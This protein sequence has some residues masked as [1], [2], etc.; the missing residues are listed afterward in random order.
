MSIFTKRGKSKIN[1]DFKPELNYLVGTPIKLQD[2][3][4]ENRLKYMNITTENLLALQE[5]KPH[6][7]EMKDQFLNEVLDHVYKFDEL[8]AIAEAHSSRER[9]ISVFSM[10]LD[11]LLEGT[12][13]EKYI[14]VRKRIGETHKRGELPVGW[15]IATYQTFNSLLI[16]Q[17]VKLYIDDPKKLSD[18]LV[19]MTDVM[20]FD[21]QLIVE[22]YLDSKVKETTLLYD[23]Q[24]QLQQELNA[25]S[26][27][28]AA[29][30]E[31]NEAG[32][33]EASTRAEKVSH[34]T[35]MTMRSNQ[36]V[37]K[38]ANTSEHDIEEMTNSF[39]VLREQMS[40]GT[41]K[42]EEMKVLS[43]S[44]SNMTGQIEQIADQTNLLALNASI[45]AARAGEAGKGFAVVADEVRKLAENSKQ[46]TKSIIDLS[47]E[48][49][50][51]T[52]ELVN[53]L[54]TMNQATTESN[55]KITDVKS[56]FS[57]VKIEMENYTDM[58]QSNKN[59]VD[60]IVKSVKELANST[61]NLASVS[62]QLLEKAK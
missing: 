42:V 20:N 13:D 37:L 51:N 24:K 36:N 1:Q 10:Y 2:N 46:I 4:L 32:L 44:I 43:E 12:I 17:I 47:S 45:E 59:E 34:D 30:V 54:E 16:P 5:L 56:S 50:H 3:I 7:L 41:K 8:V 22:T 26:Q 23:E 25:L 60:L 9:L 19:A 35:E 55:K 39:K 11:T 57:G 62:N 38:L 28:L 15:F 33:E 29:M 27:Q 14:Q 40:V 58:F 53:T 18:T 31:E 6:I 52:S 21:M 48:S 61:K 49:N